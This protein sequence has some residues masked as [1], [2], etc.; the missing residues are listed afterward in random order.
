MWLDGVVWIHLVFRLIFYCT[1]ES[2]YK[3]DSNITCPQIILVSVA[4]MFQVFAIIV[5]YIFQH[6]LIYWIWLLFTMWIIPKWLV[7]YYYTSIVLYNIMPII[8]C[9]NSIILISFNKQIRLT[10]FVS[11]SKYSKCNLV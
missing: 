8:L 6:L 9:L 2:M 1:S 11:G 3:H 7:C 10:E 4:D 5:H